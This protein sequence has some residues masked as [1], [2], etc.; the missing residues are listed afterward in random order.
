METNERVSNLLKTINGEYS[1]KSDRSHV[2]L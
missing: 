2:V 1:N